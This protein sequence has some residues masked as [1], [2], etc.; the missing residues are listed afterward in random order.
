MTGVAEICRGYRL[1]GFGALFVV[2]P[3]YVPPRVAMKNQT[4]G[5]SDV[6]RVDRELSR[7]IGHMEE[8]LKNATS[9]NDK[10]T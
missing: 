6:A 7:S 9:D 10:Q 1:P 8:S 5:E 2:S 4:V 3:R